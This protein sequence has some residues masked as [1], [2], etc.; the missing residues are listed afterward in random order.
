MIAAPFILVGYV[1]DTNALLL[2]GSGLFLDELAP[3]IKYGNN[4][5][6]KEYWSKHSII[7]TAFFVFVFCIKAWIF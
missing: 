5:H 2:I 7:W 4:F 6:S 3:L 1:A